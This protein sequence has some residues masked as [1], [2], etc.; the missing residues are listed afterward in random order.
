[1]LN[2][3]TNPVG[4]DNAIQ[5]IQ[6]QL[7]AALMVTW[8]LDPNV[9]AQNALY[10][11]YGRCYKNKRETGS[12]AEVYTGNATVP[13]SNEYKE[14]YWNDELAA[15]SFFGI[16]DRVII[17]GESQTDVH[18]IFFTDLVKLAIKD[19]VG[20]M[21]THRSDNEIHNQVQ[22][23]IG[24]SLSGLALVS[25]ET[26]LANVLRDYPGSYRDERLSVV[27]MH[28][29]HCFRFNFTIDFDTYENCKPFKSF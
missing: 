18:L 12:I 6:E 13:G 20:N 8:G 9:A 23:I 26:G 10:Q 3:K 16:A 24:N 7:H 2:L 17:K 28:P 25:I 29:R 15:I 19:N 14:V 1:M 4:I 5:S 27:D 21:V 11:C 22:Q